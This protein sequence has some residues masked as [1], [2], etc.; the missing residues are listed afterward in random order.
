MSDATI[1]I[2]AIKG[3]GT[4]TQMA[5]RFEKLARQAYDDGWGTLEEGERA[6]AESA[7]LQTEVM[8]ETA[9]S[10]I[11]KNDSPDIFFDYGLNPY[12]GCEHGC[13]YC[14]ARP[15]HSYLN[16]SPGWTLK[17][18]SSPNGTLRRCCARTWPN[19]VMCRAC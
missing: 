17:R 8:F 1:P 6:A 15:T 2:H 13:V 18:R 19:A 16:L 7:P 5:H 9:R 11:S 12:R 4:A 3:R 10:A 14:Y